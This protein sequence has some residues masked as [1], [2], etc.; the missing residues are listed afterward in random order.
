[1]SKSRLF[2]SQIL[3][4]CLVVCSTASAVAQLN[5]IDRKLGWDNKLRPNTFNQIVIV[6]QNSSGTAWKGDVRLINR[7]KQD[8]T[9]VEPSL[10][11]EPGGIRPISFI[12][13]Y[14]DGDDLMIGM[15]KEGERRLDVTNLESEGE[16]LPIA[17]QP[18]IVQITSSFGVAQNPSVPLL[19]PEYFPTTVTGMAGLQ[20]VLIEEAPDF[21]PAQNAAFLDWV[22]QG[23]ELH[24]FGSS[25]AEPLEF[26]PTLADLNQPFDSYD[27]GAGR[28]IRHKEGIGSATR[29]FVEREIRRV[30][31]RT[32]EDENE[33]VS[34]DPYAYDNNYY[35]SP[36]T[37]LFRPL[38]RITR[39]EHNWAL[40]YFLAIVYLLLIFPGGYLLGR[41]KGDYRITYG[42]II[43]VVLLF[44]LAFDLVGRRGYGEVT[45]YNYV[46]I[47]RPASNGRSQVSQ[48]GNVFVTAGGTYE[49]SHV[50][51]NAVY[52]TGTDLVV[53]GGDYAVNRPISELAV[54]IPAF[55]DRPVLNT[56]IV[57]SSIGSLSLQKFTWDEAGDY[58]GDLVLK[59]DEPEKW[60]NEIVET[61]AVYGNRIYRMQP[62]KNESLI[63]LR[64]TE[65]FHDYYNSHV[66][67]DYYANQSHG[68]REQL[69]SQTIAAALAYDMRLFS[70]K[71]FEEFELPPNRIR[72]YIVAVGNEAF[73]VGG[74]FS[75]Q[76]DG[77]V[78]YVHELTLPT[79]NVTEDSSAAEAVE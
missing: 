40:I 74:D 31:S 26:P 63:L 34:N 23:G 30:S 45:S 8:F 12:V 7:D 50:E 5:V 72:I 36:I 28:V 2:F 20:A 16:L 22:Y 79:E 24:I 64:S 67:R 62:N 61:R 14:R 68:D 42:A 25:G 9:L 73:H 60:P 29:D 76:Q 58:P 75:P 21:Q 27:L 4:L 3:A 78:I 51:D 46:A 17:D 49:I 48:F 6:V 13:F 11:I 66:F 18:A 1:M 41:F 57:D 39:P 55:S 10:F 38:Q 43:G 19:E 71:D 77:R 56:G 53:G 37:A 59:I 35:G 52:S 70:E 54:D 32:E 44:S 47:A 15:R 33:E 69:F 65:Q